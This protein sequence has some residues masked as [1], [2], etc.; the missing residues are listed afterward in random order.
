MNLA[1]T[2]GKSLLS[3]PVKFADKPAATRA[4]GAGGLAAWFQQLEKKQ[5][6]CI[7]VASVN[8]WQEL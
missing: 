1:V 2:A 6:I 4:V 3:L 7:A 8:R 5:D